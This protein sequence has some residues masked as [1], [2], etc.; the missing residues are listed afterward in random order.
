[1]NHY[2]RVF[3]ASCR[4][5]LLAPRNC[6]TPRRSLLT[7]A[8]ETS[9]DDTSVAVLEAFDG[10]NGRTGATLY[11][12]KKVTSNNTEYHGVHPLASL[13]SHQENL[14]KLVDEAILSLPP[15]NKDARSKSVWSKRLPDFVSVTRGPGMRSNLFT[16]L[17]T[18]KGLAA[19]WQVDLVGVHHMQA[20]A[21]TP[22]L[23]SALQDAKTP[24]SDSGSPLRKVDVN[25]EF[26]FLSV[27]A[28]GGHTLLIHSSSLTEHRV[29]ASTADIAVGECLDKV[30]R[31]VL[32][33]DVLTSAKTTM[34]GPLLEK[35]AFPHASDLE[36]REKPRI[37]T[38]GSAQFL[39][40]DNTAAEYQAMYATRYAYVVP[41]NQEEALR[42]NKTKWGWAFNQPLVRAG[43]GLKSRSFELSFS[44][45]L[46]AAERAFEFE[47][48][49]VTGRLNKCSRTPDDVSLEERKDMAREAMRAAF[50][51]V[52][53][54]VVLALQQT[55]FENGPAS[56]VPTVVMSGGVAANAFLRYILA[57]TLVAH[58]FPHARVVFPPVSLCTDNAA[59]I[60]WAGIEMYA[61][62]YSD[63]RE[64]RALRKWPLDE[65]LSPCQNG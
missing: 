10:S 40:E 18:A 57:S 7:L 51:H 63:P 31:I 58:G 25:P 64:I 27:L 11:F 60:A 59:M 13:Y 29:L 6:A 20:H 8:I 44:G 34:Y 4:P 38:P 3:A 53:D 55:A 15:K 28:S 5:R 61:A 21:L 17:D 41:K 37:E 19:A 46:S 35:F 32:P 23:V 1:M 16:G 36:P 26:P 56:N 24:H 22:R 48:D 39:L 45:L 12:H 62:G 9:C 33:S 49:L 2:A 65:L 54:R 30:A 43:G 42:Q 52:A 14:A 47:R 50:E